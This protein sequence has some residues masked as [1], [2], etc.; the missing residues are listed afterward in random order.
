MPRGGPERPI[1]GQKLTLGSQKDVK[2]AEKYD[3]EKD[4]AKYYEKVQKC[5]HQI[6]QKRWF[7]LDET[8]VFEKAT[9]S[10]KVTKMT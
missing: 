8:H 7:R 6:P 5:S 10:E 1:L 9:C 2:Y 3:S 4:T